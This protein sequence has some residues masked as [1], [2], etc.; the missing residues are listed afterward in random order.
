MYILMIVC[1]LEKIINQNFQNFIILIILL[2][3][4][5]FKLFINIFF[6]S[7]FFFL[8]LK[9]FINHLLGFRIFFMSHK[10]LYKIFHH[11]VYFNFLKFLFVF[12][13]LKNYIHF[14]YNFNNSFKPN[15]EEFLFISFLFHLLN[16]KF[17][18]WTLIKSFIQ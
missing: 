10:P 16:I 5:I 8:N 18:L 3:N 9:I 2:F 15:F 7:N 12:L 11:E 4:C 1:I 6:Q 14:F 17:L 13:L